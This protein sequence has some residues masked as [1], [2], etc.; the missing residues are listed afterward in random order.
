MH[1]VVQLSEEETR[2]ASSF[3]GWTAI[4]LILEDEVIEFRP[5]NEPEEYDEEKD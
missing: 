2:E 3:H 4:Y 5:G 1:H